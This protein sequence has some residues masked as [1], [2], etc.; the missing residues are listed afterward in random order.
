ML[1]T[2]INKFKVDIAL[3][4]IVLEYLAV[5][6]PSQ[7]FFG[8]SESVG[9]SIDDEHRVSAQTLLH[10][11]KDC[12]QYEDIVDD[13]EDERTSCDLTDDSNKIDSDA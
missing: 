5:A 11:V 3:A 4:L 7:H 12:I 1:V 6:H 9:A 8:T 10:V 13:D 2:K